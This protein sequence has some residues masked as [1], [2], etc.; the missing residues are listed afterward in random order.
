MKLNKDIYRR[1]V[2]H[3]ILEDKE[4]IDLA[5]GAQKA[6]KMDDP[7]KP[8]LYD[9]IIAYR[10]SRDPGWESTST[11]YKITDVTKFCSHSMCSVK[12]I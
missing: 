2:W 4:Y 3:M 5:R 6:I 1:K 10:E 12:Q 8:I 7:K 9:L 11:I